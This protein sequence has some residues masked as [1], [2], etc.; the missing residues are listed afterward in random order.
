MFIAKNLRRLRLQAD[1][2][3][4]ELAERL[5]VSGQAVS[6]WEREEC[7]PDIT[8]LPG[9]A[10]LFNCTVD[11]IL[12]M[13]ELNERQKLSE[14]WNEMY[15]LIR[16]GKYAEAIDFFEG[17]LRVYP[18]DHGYMAYIAGLRAITG[19]DPERAIA[20]CERAVAEYS[21]EKGRATARAVL[22]WLYNQYRSPEKAAETVRKLPHAWE[23]REFLLPRFLP[24]AERVAYLRRNIPVILRAMADL[25]N[26]KVDG[27]WVKTI[28]AG[29]Y[30]DDGDMGDVLEVIK[31]FTS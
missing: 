28:L 25:I 24:E 7:Y 13:A 30:D 15:A 17:L 16:Q 6:K 29:N 2:T 26:N 20:L 5:H 3:Q 14:T 22:A 27:E 1:M 10:N 31:D 4:E 19:D 12:G 21:G 8:L 11:E 18:N 23:A 9:L